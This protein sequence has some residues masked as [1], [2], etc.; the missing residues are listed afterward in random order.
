MA[1][2]AIANGG[3]LMRPLLVEKI[4]NAKGKVVK[5]FE[6]E[7]KRQVINPTTAALVREILRKVVVKGTGQGANI[8]GYE[9]GG[10]TGTSQKVNPR[11]GKYYHDKHIASFVGFFPASHPRVVI[12]VVIDEPHPL[13]YGG[14]VAAPVFKE[15]A[16]H[17]IW[18][19]HL[20]PSTSSELKMA[21]R[22][23]QPNPIP[24]SS[25]LDFEGIDEAINKGIMPNLQGLPLRLAL[26]IL[27]RG[28]LQVKIKGT[29][30][31]IKQFPAPGTKIKEDTVC[32]L[33]L[34]VNE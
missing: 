10:K 15:I 18:Y 28:N 16:Q 25:S 21:K 9:I 3:K 20:A 6:P 26:R 12:V 7:V 27:Q 24:E 22:N 14:I 33:Q 34:G 32:L 2:S 11:T 23:S 30:W 19:W 1:Y 13:Y 17:I 4:Y 29:G 31:V 8:P 5:V